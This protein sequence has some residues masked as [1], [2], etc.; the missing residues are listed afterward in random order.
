MIQ[1]MNAGIDGILRIQ[2]A[3]Y[4][5]KTSR[6][7][8]QFNFKC[9]LDVSNISRVNSIFYFEGRYQQ[10]FY[11]EMILAKIQIYRYK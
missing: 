9:F 1:F 6:L 11:T 8:Q 7:S 2:T 5:T 10:L 3:V 4:A